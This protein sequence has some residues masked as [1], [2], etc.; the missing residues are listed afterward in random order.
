L[1]ARG[2][3]YG[4]PSSL[5]PLAAGDAVGAEG[6]Q[7]DVDDGAALGEEGAAVSAG[8]DLVLVEC[9]VSNDDETVLRPD[10]RVNGEEEAL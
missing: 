2:E 5:D 7:V 4:S 6:G 3:S 1:D 10:K 8:E 9:D